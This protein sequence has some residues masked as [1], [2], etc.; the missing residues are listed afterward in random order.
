MSDAV[1]GLLII[2]FVLGTFVGYIFNVVELFKC[3]FEPIGKAEV[4]RTIGVFMPPVGII[5]GYIDIEDSK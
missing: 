1:K 3:D 5:A 2:I 4:V